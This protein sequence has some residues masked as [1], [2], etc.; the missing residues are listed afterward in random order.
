[1]DCS[2]TPAKSLIKWFAR[3]HPVGESPPGLRA[4]LLNP[5]RIAPGYRSAFWIVRLEAY[6]GDCD[7]EADSGQMRTGVEI[8][9]TMSHNVLKS[10][11]EHVQ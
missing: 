11:E 7:I 8:L 6:E 3:A 4:A 5:P 1:M 9:L 2:Y 10:V